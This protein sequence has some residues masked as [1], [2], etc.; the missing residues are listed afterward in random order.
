MSTHLSEG[1]MGNEDMTP[2]AVA[3]DLKYPVFGM[4]P[5]S[6]GTRV[7]SAKMLLLFGLDKVW[8]TRCVALK[9]WSAEISI[10]I[11]RRTSY[12]VRRK[13]PTISSCLRTT[14]CLSQISTSIMPQILSPAPSS[15]PLGPTTPSSSRRL[16]TTS[17]RS[18]SLIGAIDAPSGG[19]S[20]E[21][22][23]DELRHTSRK[24]EAR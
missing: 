1:A 15:P 12:H 9:L 21:T 10:A 19:S 24:L 18:L 2:A 8:K 22:L 3:H 13:K 17:T 11:C 4:C 7:T 6:V 5:R 14:T 23:V 20:I 16:S